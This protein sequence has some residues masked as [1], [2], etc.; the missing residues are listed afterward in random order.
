MNLQCAPPQCG[1]PTRS[2]A[3]RPK[4]SA[5]SI[6]RPRRTNMS[7]GPGGS[8]TSMESCVRMRA[9]LW[10]RKRLRM[11]EPPYRPLRSD[12]WPRAHKRSRWKSRPRR[13]ESANFDTKTEESRTGYV[14][15]TRKASPSKGLALRGE[16]MFGDRPEGEGGQI[17]QQSDDHDHRE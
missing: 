14:G 17:L 5:I 2:C 7:A 4:P 6:S 15:K 1:T 12:T 11:D 3:A 8:P 16:E 10:P 13:K 9:A